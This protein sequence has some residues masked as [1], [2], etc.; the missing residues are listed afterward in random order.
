MQI[1]EL[2]SVLWTFINAC[3]DCVVV[4]LHKVVHVTFTVDLH[5]FCSTSGCFLVYVLLIGGFQ[6]QHLLVCVGNVQVS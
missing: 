4:N 3:L 5:K 6:C 1:L 2:S